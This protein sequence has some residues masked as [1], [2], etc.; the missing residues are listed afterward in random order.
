MCIHIGLTLFMHNLSSLKV[1]RTTLISQTTVSISAHADH[2]L[3]S[4]DI[5]VVSCYLLSQLLDKE[6]LCQHQSIYK[7]VLLLSPH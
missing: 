2:V 4:N 6:A 7:Q 1:S 5:R 3:A